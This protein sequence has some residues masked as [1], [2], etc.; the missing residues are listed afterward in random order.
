MS[1]NRK[2]SPWDVDLIA[3]IEAAAQTECKAT[4]GK[5]RLILSVSRAGEWI[6]KPHAIEALNAAFV[7]RLEKIFAPG[8]I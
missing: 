1:D 8:Q 5:D 4:L 2:L 6:N 3:M 7:V